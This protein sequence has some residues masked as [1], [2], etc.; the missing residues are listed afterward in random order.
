[1]NVVYQFQSTIPYSLHDMRTS[2]VEI[3]G[4]NIRFYFDEGYV[5]T[6]ENFSQVAG[7]ILIENVDFDFSYIH[8]LSDNGAY[9]DFIGKKMEIPKFMKDYN[10]FSFEIVDETYGYHTI[11]YAG[12]LSLPN[13]EHL[14]D[15]SISLYYTG[16]IIYE[17]TD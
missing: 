11:V 6:K 3:I 14:I 9:G 5:E 1:M 8:F 4:K 13:K 2:K 15:M 17:V 10:H 12:Y 7:N 16:N